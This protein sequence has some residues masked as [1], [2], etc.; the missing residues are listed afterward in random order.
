MSLKFQVQR[1]SKNEYLRAKNLP[2]PNTS[3]A[4]I[5]EPPPKSYLVPF[6]PL[7]ADLKEQENSVEKPKH[8]GISRNSE[9]PSLRNSDIERTNLIS[10]IV[11]LESQLRQYREKYLN[12]ESE[13]RTLNQ[14]KEEFNKSRE[15][16][17]YLRSRLNDEE[18]KNR[19]LGL[20]ARQENG[21]KIREVERMLENK[22]RE[23]DGL[24]KWGKDLEASKKMSDNKLKEK[25]VLIE[26][27]A[28]EIE[29]SNDFI[30]S[31]AADNQFFKS[32]CQ[33]LEK[34]VEKY[35]KLV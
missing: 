32:K 28:N 1:L 3:N 26:K 10:Q 11:A 5:P 12:L 8:S 25:D 2:H 13:L 17:E 30:K 18:E 4:L 19:K 31:L 21:E 24:L 23:N 9:L 6:T 27:L 15:E 16:A 33:M 22:I 34:E 20:L 14:L 7:P 35:Y 29:S